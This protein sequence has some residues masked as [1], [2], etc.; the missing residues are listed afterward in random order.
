MNAE[1]VVAAVRKHAAERRVAINNAWPKHLTRKGY[2]K[3]V[4]E[5]A[6]LERLE[7]VLQDAIKR[8]NAADSEPEEDA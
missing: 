6:E 7:T 3:L 5:H 4:G 8:A 1:L 2:I